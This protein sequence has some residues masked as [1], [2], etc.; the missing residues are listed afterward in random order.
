[1]VN[2]SMPG[3]MNLSRRAKGEEEILLNLNLI[4]SRYQEQ[5]VWK[6]NKKKK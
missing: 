2:L 5:N 1:M 4:L 6:T 3:Q